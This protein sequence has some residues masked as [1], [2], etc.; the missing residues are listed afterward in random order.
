MSLLIQ[1]VVVVVLFGF[2]S[3]GGNVDFDAAISA[4]FVEPETARASG[5]PMLVL[6]TQP[7]CGACKNLKRAI[8]ANAPSFTSLL[9]EFAVVHAVGDDGQQ[10]MEDGHGYVPQ[11]Y[12]LAAGGESDLGVQGPNPKYAHFFADE[13]SLATAMNSA[14]EKAKAGGSEL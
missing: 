12:F 7:W 2:S 6:V 13:P 3:A 1:L 9:N 14:L 4:H 8:N 10:W 11:T 5:K